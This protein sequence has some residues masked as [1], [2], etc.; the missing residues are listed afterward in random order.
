MTGQRLLHYQILDK[1]GE[2]GMGVVYKARDTHLDR[3]VAI[4]LL[5][6]EKVSDPARKARFI[7]EAK[8][9]SALN[10]PNII[11]VHDISHEDGIDFMVME[12]IDGKTLDQLIPRKGMRLNEA[13]KIA[14]QIADA[15]ARAHAAG[16]I[17]RDIKPANIMVDVHGQAKVLDFGLAKLT[18][19]GDTAE[20]STATAAVKTA[21][22]TIAGTAA[23][24]S[25]EQ[26]E[27]KPLDA[28]SDIFSLGAVLYEMFTGRRAFRGDTRLSTLAAVI[29][30]DPDVL[31]GGI[32]PELIRTITRCLRKD[33]AWRFQTMADLKVTLAELTTESGSERRV[34]IPP[35]RRRSRLGLAARIG[36][37]LALAVV[38]T[39]LWMAWR[40]A[41]N[42]EEVPGI[43]PL[44]AY[45]GSEITPSFSPDGSQVAFAWNG[46]ILKNYDIY[47]KRIDSE[48]PLRLTSDPAPDSYPAWSPDGRWIAFHRGGSEPGVYLVSP[49]GGPQRRLTAAA[50][51]QLCWSSDSKF[52]VYSY[53]DSERTPLS[54]W[55]IS[56]SDGERQRLT[57]PPEGF[58]GDVGCAVSP[59][60]RDLVFGRWALGGAGG[61]GVWLVPLAGGQPRRL[62]AANL[63]V[64]TVAWLPAG[65]EVVF[66]A[67][68]SDMM[69]AS[70]WVFGYG[71][72]TAWRLR[73]PGSGE[74][75][76]RRLTG[77]DQE[78]GWFSASR[79]AL[80]GPTRLAYAR[81]EK[82][83]NIYRFEI[84]SRASS[85]TPTPVCPSTRSDI[86]PAISPDGRKILF[87][88]QRS[89]KLELWTCESDG[90]NPV[91]ITNTEGIVGAPSWSPDGR[92]IA[93]DILAGTNRDIFVMNSDGTGLRRMTT[94]PANDGLATWSKSGE[95]IY[96]HS[97]R[98]EA[99]EIWK[100]PAE[101]GS[102]ARLTAGGGYEPKESPDG[103]LVYYVKSNDQGGLWAVSVDGGQEREVIAGIR[104]GNWTVGPGGIYFLG[105]S[106]DELKKG[107]QLLDPATG[108]LTRLGIVEDATSSR[109][110][111]RLSVAP[112]GKWLL[113]TRLDTLSADLM[114]VENFR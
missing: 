22:G 101:G 11:T 3:F 26:A 1:L 6:P 102:P 103:S 56:I 36:G 87:A 25:P 88:S 89:G 110:N 28:R 49:L 33:P 94:D 74:A 39:L 91:Q 76:P 42:E 100:M 75:V 34:E 47:V 29:G 46:G 98:S 16:I 8:A 60:G 44:T 38:A 12:F 2:G 15:L 97:A 9:A 68:G 114:L 59:N 14:T 108:K 27:G 61:A 50:I 90:S 43:V 37:A 17:H 19:Q 82:D 4:K 81:Y 95:W 48:P 40:H 84:N 107:V 112:D 104:R 66:N 92:K 41:L 7:Q 69:A 73:I 18:E 70:P 99:T 57:F 71:D 54:K 24:M 52:L 5:P 64:Q 45:P 105:A 72:T 13:L 77:I 35:P 51:T 83:H 113:F 30:Q 63:G 23:Y 58:L 65:D 78:S 32:P 80:G 96:F 21:E 31:Q 85:P 106:V 109:N 79:A 86:W 20:A 62:T 93:F 10:H 53:R 55:K 111:P 67:L